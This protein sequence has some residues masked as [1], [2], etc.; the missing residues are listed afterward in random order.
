VSSC[1]PGAHAAVW[2]LSTSLAGQPIEMTI[3]ADPG[4][5]PEISYVLQACLKG[6]GSSNIRSAA[7][8]SLRS[9]EGLTTPTAPGNYRWR[10]VVTPQI[11]KPY[12]LQ[13]LVPLP[14]SVTVTTRYDR[15]RKRTI[16]SGTVVEGGKPVLGVPVLVRS[17][18]NASD[19]EIWETRTDD[20]GQYSIQARTTRTTDFTVSVSPLFGPCAGE[21]TAEG[22]CLGSMTVPPEDEF[23]TAWVSVRDGAARKIRATDQRRAEQAGLNRSDLPADFESTLG[24]GDA[25]LN[26]AHESQ[27]TITGESTSPA[28][29]QVNTEEPITIVQAIGLTRVY[30]TAKQA[31]QAFAHQARRSTLRCVITGL[32]S[33]PP[34]KPVRLPGVSARQRA[35]RAPIAISDSTSGNYDLILLQRGRSITILKFF[36]LN[37]PTAFEQELTA[38]LA[39][40]LR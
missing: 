40:R 24:G 2:A 39:S 8:I 1:A 31:R 11:R 27:L 19:L 35:F 15:G 12:E 21:T 36:D 29:Y 18:R 32:G 4:K 25:C 20:R 34:I 13:A 5:T 10:A 33:K 16:V 17:Q 37:A 30:A 26:P 14:E 23:A 9:V 3:F 22:G 28:F 38:K 6:L 7:S